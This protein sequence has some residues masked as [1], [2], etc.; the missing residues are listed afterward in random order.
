MSRAG[1][2]RS[3]HHAGRAPRTSR[4]AGAVRWMRAAPW[5]S[6]RDTFRYRALDEVTKSSERIRRASGTHHLLDG[7]MGTMVQRRRPDEA[8]GRGARFA[9]YGRELR[10]N[11]EVLSTQPG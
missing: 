7:A 11:N 5:C 1:D 2:A 4:P 10:G 3:A 8:T 6:G 9:D